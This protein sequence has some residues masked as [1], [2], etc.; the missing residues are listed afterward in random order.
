MITFLKLSN[1]HGYNKIS[2]NILTAISQF[3][4]LPLTYICNQSLSTGIFPSQPKFSALKYL[5]KKG[6]RVSK[7]QTSVITIVL[8]KIF[9]KLMYM[10]ENILISC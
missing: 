8:S 2:T 4:I 9:E 3:I 10:Y 6:N 7:L 5:F 1:S